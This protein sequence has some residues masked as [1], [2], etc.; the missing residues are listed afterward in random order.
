MWQGILQIR[1]HIDVPWCIYEDFNSPLHSED[2][3]GGN[4]IA[5]SKTKDFQKIV[6]DLNLV[7]MKATGGHFTSANKHVWSKID[8]AISNEVWVM[9]Y[10]SIT[11]QFQEQIL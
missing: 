1:A 9:Q 3:L 5:E 4:P 11:A 6:E 7:D 10:G 8:R 2:R